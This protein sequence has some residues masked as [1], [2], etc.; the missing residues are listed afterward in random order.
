ME[1]TACNVIGTPLLQCHEVPY[2]IHDLSRIEDP[3]YRL[4]WYHLLLVNLF[5]FHILHFRESFGWFFLNR[6]LMDLILVYRL[7]H[8][9]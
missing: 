2:H 7:L 8:I 6:R 1:R 9:P 4:L 5:V 3:V